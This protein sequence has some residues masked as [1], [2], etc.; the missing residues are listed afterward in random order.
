[1]DKRT[2]QVEVPKSILGYIDPATIAISERRSEPAD[3][4]APAVVERGDEP[5]SQRR[6]AW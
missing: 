5:S 2:Q 4:M 3:C 6:I 1:M